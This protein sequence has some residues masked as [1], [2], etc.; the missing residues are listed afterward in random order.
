MAVDAYYHIFNRGVDKRQIF[1]DDEDHARF[2]HDMYEFND[3]ELAPPYMCRNKGDKIGIT[4]GHPTSNSKTSN[5]KKRIVEIVCFCLM[6]NHFHFILKPL[7]EGGISL[8]MKKIGSGYAYYFNLK[9]KRSG[10][11]FQG[12]F[13]AKLIK[14]DAQMM[15]LARYIHVL[16]PGELVEP[17]IR[18]GILRNPA[19]LKDFLQNYKWSSFQ[20]YLGQK[21]YSSLT[22]KNLLS[23]YFGNEKEFEK[24]SLSWRNDDFEKINDIILE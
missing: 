17:K 13:K 19:G 20:D 5:S 3:T 18:E 1:M 15:H 2:L 16:N 12:R 6:P 4:I 21:N 10:A 23:G 9:N 11:L 22:N 14:T 7:V 24:F 8:F